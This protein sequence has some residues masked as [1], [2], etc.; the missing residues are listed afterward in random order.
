M[1]IRISVIRMEG[2][3][4][5][6][7]LRVRVAMLRIFENVLWAFLEINIPQ[8][9]IAIGQEMREIHVICVQLLCSIC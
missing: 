6:Q 5:S 1:P 9:L 3:K 7:L 8:N 4:Y 2:Q